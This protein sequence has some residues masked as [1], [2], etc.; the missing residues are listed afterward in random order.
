ME[1]HGNA[2]SE[3]GAK[4]QKCRP[5]S[6]DF[7]RSI[8]SCGCKNVDKARV[9]LKATFLLAPLLGITYIIMPIHQSSNPSEIGTSENEPSTGFIVFIYLNTI[10][11]GFQ[12][13]IV[14]TFYCFVNSEIQ[15]HLKRKIYGLQ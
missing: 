5:R 9:G 14:S 12:G 11:Q 15:R 6:N 3:D 2:S 10:L 4:F 1:Y 8:R 7:V 13:A